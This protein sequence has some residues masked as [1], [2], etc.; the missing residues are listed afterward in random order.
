MVAGLGL[1]VTAMPGSDL[2]GEPARTPGTQ[3]ELM[4][5]GRMRDY[6]LAGTAWLASLFENGM[7]GILGDEMGL[8]KTVQTIAF[9]AHLFHRGV[10]GP[11][12]V[13]GPLGVLAN[14]Q[15]EVGIWCPT[16]TAQLYHGNR[17]ERARLRQ[18]WGDPH[19]TWKE[20]A[21]LT[22]DEG[23]RLKNKDSALIQALKSLP[24]SNRLLL[25][26]T[27]LPNDLAEMW[28]LLN[29]ILPDIFVSPAQFQGWFDSDHDVAK[30]HSSMRPFVA[31]F[32]LR[33]RKED[34]ERPS[35]EE[36]G[37]ESFQL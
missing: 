12:L 31:H 17:A 33:R 4:T 37:C 25:T 16:M 19:P 32:M 1:G 23:H 26:G 3:P 35:I 6:Q 9:L 36:E 18:D 34:V 24:V 22:V 29:F 28:S 21:H 2:H 7:N 20:W 8:G 5:G 27:P 13:V 15:R 10:E 30:L 11:F 14:W